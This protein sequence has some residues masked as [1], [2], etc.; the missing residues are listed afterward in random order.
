MAR[1]LGVLLAR[2]SSDKPV[3]GGIGD[4]SQWYL[5]NGKQPA[6]MMKSDRIFGEGSVG[7]SGMSINPE[8][9]L[10]T[11]IDNLDGMVFRGLFDSQWTMI[12]VSAGCSALTGY[13]PE[14]VVRNHE[15]SY[16]EITHPDDREKV[17][18]VIHDAVSGRKR[19]RVDYRIIRADGAMRWVSES[20]AVVVDEKGDLV[21]EGFVCDITDQI[22]IREAHAAAVVRYRSIFENTSEGVFQTSADGRYIDANPALAKMYG[23]ASPEELISAFQNIGQQLYVD[24]RRRDVFK[25]I[26]AGQGIVKDFEAQVRRRDGEIIWISENARAVHAS[27]GTFLYY[28][29][30][31]QDITERKRYQDQLEHQASHDQLTGLPN[32]N[33]LNDRLQQSIL[34]A[35]RY[36]YYAALAFI[37]LD[38]FKYINDSLGHLVGDKLLIEVA[39]RLKA[40]LRTSDTV[41]RYGGD[42]F[43][44]LLNNH[45]SLGTI[46]KVLERVLEEIGHP[47]EISS[48]EL[49]VTCSIGVA[50]YPSDG[51]D[52]QSLL[53]NADAAMYLAKERGKNNFQFYTKGLNAIA[54]ERVLLEAALRRALDRNE[55]KVYFQPKVD[56]HG[57][58]VGAE[59]LLRWESAEMGWVSPDRFIGI[60][61]DTGLIEP[62]TTFVLLTACQQAVE[63]SK[64]GL[65]LLKVAVN[66]SARSFTQNNLP[67]LIQDV[68]KETGLE[69]S[70]LELELTESAIIDSPERC[71]TTLHALKKLGVLLAIDD[72]GTGYSS[73][74]YLQ[75]FPVD[76]LKIDRSFV[77][78]LGP[79]TDDSHIAKLIVLLGQGLRLRVVAEGV[80]NDIQRTYLDA[81][82]CDEFQGY[83]FAKPMPVEEFWGYLEFA[84]H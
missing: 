45:Y 47:L 17:G 59:A 54:T 8:R 71:I 52:A 22:E 50:L 16:F 62:I 26:M 10:H 3:H 23:Y 64:S 84:S 68:L 18:N 28:E 42:E 12:F 29:G 27:D 73:L 19:Y 31:V 20:G 83:L 56:R 74:S 60:A 30:T 13:T 5:F 34:A 32:R 1:H 39:S 4:K 70:R 48:Q 21:I 38:N 58:A 24:A 75:R 55:L 14:Q 9:V 53:R 78:S 33:L 69:P 80:E 7:V 2:T 61:E 46:V 44:L 35:Q 57:K 65:G 66:L 37:D 82:G 43:V 40:C 15:I 67:K 72:F 11:L 25:Q 76:I 63:W 36:S 81:W 51:E 79:A 49:F 6:L 41:A 77:S